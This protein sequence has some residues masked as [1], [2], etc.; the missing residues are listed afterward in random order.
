[1]VRFVPEAPSCVEYSYNPSSIHPLFDQNKLLW[2]WQ[3][4]NFMIKVIAM[5]ALYNATRALTLYAQN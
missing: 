5:K 1:M 4:I 2:P 3:R